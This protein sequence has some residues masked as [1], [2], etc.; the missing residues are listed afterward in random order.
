MSALLLQACTE[1]EMYFES[2]NETDMFPPMAFTEEV[3]RQY[4][5]KRWAVLPRPGWLK[6]Q[7]WGDG[8]E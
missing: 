1:V 2:N 7:F 6:I 4:C 8:E 5:S 3:R